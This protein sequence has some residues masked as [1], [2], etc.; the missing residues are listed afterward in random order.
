[1]NI[2]ELSNDQ[3]LKDR[4]E[5]AESLAEVVS[6]YRE[7]GIEVTE[8]ELEAALKAAESDELKEDD[9][10]EVAGGCIIF[11]FPWPF[12]PPFGWPRRPWPRKKR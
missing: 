11:P 3:E 1:M 5:N 2:E 9:L 10:E 12:W 7:K 8:A 4:I 6:L